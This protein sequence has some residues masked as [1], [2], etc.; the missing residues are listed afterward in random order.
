MIMD[1]I[2]NSNKRNLFGNS[3]N[4]E[5]KKLPVELAVKNFIEAISF[6]L[7]QRS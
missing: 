2:D 4:N 1:L 7:S 5:I 6:A 3:L